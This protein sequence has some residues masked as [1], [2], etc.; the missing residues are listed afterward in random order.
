MLNIFETIFL[1]L[2]RFRTKACAMSF[3]TRNPDASTY[4]NTS[5]DAPLNGIDCLIFITEK[6]LAL[7]SHPFLLNK[8]FAAESFSNKTKVFLF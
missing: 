8:A 4:S 2:R 7:C 1:H 3:L 6:V 5:S